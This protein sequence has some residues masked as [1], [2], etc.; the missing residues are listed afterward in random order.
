MLTEEGVDDPA[1]LASRRCWIADPLDGTSHFV[2]G[3]DDFD[4][5]VALTVDGAP[6]VAVSLQPVTGL[7]LGATAGRGAWVQSGDGPRRSLVLAPGTPRRIATKAWLGAPDNLPALEAAASALG[8]T[9][10]EA[11]WSLCPRCFVPP[12]ASIDAMVGLSVGRAVDASEWDI[13]PVD[14]IVR[15]A[16]GA[17]TDPRGAP[18][19][20]NQPSPS[21]A[22][23][24]IIAADPGLHRDLVAALRP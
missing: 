4:T 6:V 15:E 5:F 16:G 20:Y 21:F 17:A 23:G 12:S 10:L 18:L 2:A 22:S 14:L 8:A 13:A 19:C 9:L 24:L 7:M 1:R 3:L 11:T